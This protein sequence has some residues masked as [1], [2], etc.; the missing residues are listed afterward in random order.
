[1]NEYLRES[2]KEFSPY[3]CHVRYHVESSN[4]HIRGYLIIKELYYNKM[5]LSATGFISNR[6]KQNM[7]NERQICHVPLLS[8]QT[9]YNVLFPSI[10]AFFSFSQS[11]RNIGVFLTRF[12]QDRKQ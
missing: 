6:S 9:I 10:L 11:K 8:I 2:M 4:R 12:S 5:I 3:L 1:M 7:L